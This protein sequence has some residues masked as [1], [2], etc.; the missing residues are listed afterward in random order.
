MK[1]EHNLP[2]PPSGVANWADDAGSADSLLLRPPGGGGGGGGGP[3][4]T[5]QAESVESWTTWHRPSGDEL[6]DHLGVSLLPP[7]DHWVQLEPGLK[8]KRWGGRCGRGW[9]EQERREQSCLQARGLAVRAQST[10]GR[11]WGRGLCKLAWAG[12]LPAPCSVRR[13]GTC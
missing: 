5:E 4:G 8:L 6:L 11:A 12:R 2:R 7:N 9:D 13:V 1:K 3:D 10:E